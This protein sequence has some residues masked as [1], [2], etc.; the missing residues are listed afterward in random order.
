MAAKGMALFVVVCLAVVGRC[1][2]QEAAERLN[3]AADNLKMRAQG[4]EQQASEAMHDAKDRVD[5]WAD[6]ALNKFSE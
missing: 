1:W 4:A 2:G 5:S 6:W 3:M